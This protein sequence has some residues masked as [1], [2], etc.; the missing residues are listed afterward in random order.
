MINGHALGLLAYHEKLASSIGPL[1][2]DMDRNRRN[3]D[4]KPKHDVTPNGRN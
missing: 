4:T 2:N 1:A 3:L